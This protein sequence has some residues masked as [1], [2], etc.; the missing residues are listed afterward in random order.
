MRTKAASEM[1]TRRQ[2]G[3]IKKLVTEYD[4]SMDVTLV[5]LSCN[6][7]DKL[8]RIPQRWFEPVPPMCA[9]SMEEPDEIMKIHHCS[10]HP[11]VRRTCYFIRLTNPSVS[12]NAVRAVVKGCRTCQSIDPAPVKWRKGKLGVTR[13]WSRLGMD[14]S[15][16]GGQNFLMLIDCGPTRFTV[17]RPLSRQ[18]LSSIICQLELVF[19]A[20]DSSGA[21]WTNRGS[22]FDYDVHMCQVVMA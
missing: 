6:L 22:S 9:A 12:T 8:T 19:Y 3:T 2:L 16:Y 15:H 17:W 18:D 5:T 1:L 10:G 7:A 21:S 11:G 4:L 13:T 14:I 20:V